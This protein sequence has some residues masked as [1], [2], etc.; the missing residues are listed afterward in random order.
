MH[1]LSKSKD[2]CQPMATYMFQGPRLDGPPPDGMGAILDG[3][4]FPMVWIQDWTHPPDDMGV[5]KSDTFCV[6][7][8]SNDQPKYGAARKP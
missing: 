4:T 5:E 1:K 2:S 8:L 3:P 6:Y 7:S